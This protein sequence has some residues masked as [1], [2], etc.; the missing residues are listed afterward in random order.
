MFLQIP[1]IATFL[2]I[3]LV[4]SV[5]LAQQVAPD[6]TVLE[7]PD[8]DIFLIDLKIKSDSIELSNPRNI[9]D[10]PGYDNQ[11]WFTPRGTTVLYTA[12]GAPDRTDIYEYNIATKERT[13]LTDSQQQEYSPQ[14]SP[15]D[16]QLSFV[17]DG[18]DAN[19][20]INTLLRGS[21]DQEWLLAKHPDREPV[22][23]YSWNRSTDDI[24]LWSRY[25]YSL[26]LVHR[27]KPIS[28]YICGNAVPSS[29]HIIPNT[30]WFSFL[31]RQGNSEVWIKRLEPDTLSVRPIIQTAGAGFHY[32]WTPQGQLLMPD[33]T[34][35]MM[36]NPAVKSSWEEVASF[37]DF[38]IRA[39]T[40]LA[41]SPNGRQLAV[42]GLPQS[43]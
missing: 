38:G 26:R 20:S 42:V 3:C 7:L 28:H 14:S 36:A 33:G 15:D 40:R 24:L 34:S 41:V 32:A 10:R 27:T 37:A 2:S 16:K 8:C 31:H 6:P 43:R 22:G 30:T 13:Q 5:V 4:C 23:Y 19:L 18:A 25:G 1:S 35:L 39:V 11:P 12:N 17:T 9:T 29:P 21:T